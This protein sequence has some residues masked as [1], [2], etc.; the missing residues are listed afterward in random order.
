MSHTFDEFS[1]VVGDGLIPRR[2][3]LRRLGTAITATVLS[4]LGA[5]FARAGQKRK[6]STDLCKE[7][8]K[9]RNKRQQDQ[10]LKTCKACGSNPQRLGGGCGNYFCCGA[11]QVSCGDYCA[12]LTNDP[13]NCGDCG[14]ACDPP[15]ENEYVVCED[16]RCMYACYDGAVDCSGQCKYLDSDPNNC[17]ACGNV[18][19][20]PNPHCYEG[21]C[22]ECSPDQ[23]RCG[24]T[25]ADV[26][27]DPDNCGACGNV[28]GGS[29]PY[30]SYGACTDCEGAGGAICG[31]VCVDIL[32]DA[33]NCGACGNQCAPLEFCSF[34]ACSGSD[35]YGS[36][37]DGYYGGEAGWW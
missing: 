13:W 17:G 2:E 28:C 21:V 3:S 24:N 15:G 1:K 27:W 23:V 22:S 4:P 33:L 20:G 10:C 18:C 7:F 12:D 32:F 25:C 11:G 34:G 8:C 5:E 35:G 19:T 9:C 6:G 31:G 37:W 26:S 29:T 30:C 16:G 14:Y 36:G